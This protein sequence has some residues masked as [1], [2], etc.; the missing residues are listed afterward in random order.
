MDI[1]DFFPS[2]TRK[3]LIEL[4]RNNSNIIQEKS[5]SLND[6]EYILDVVLYNGE[7]LVIGS[8]ASPVI[9]NRIMYNF[10]KD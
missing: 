2:I 5:L 3:M 9:S 4:F 8:V 6:I 1:K 10:D 7:K